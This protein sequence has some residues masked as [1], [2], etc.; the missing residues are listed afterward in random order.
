MDVPGTWLRWHLGSRNKP[1]N[2]QTGRK[3]KE[4]ILQFLLLRG[5][6][7]PPGAKENPEHLHLEKLLFRPISSSPCSSAS[8]GIIL[9]GVSG[10]WRDRKSDTSMAL[11]VSVCKSEGLTIWLLCPREGEGEEEEE[12]KVWGC[13]WG[14]GC[15]E[16]FCS[17]EE[18]SFLTVTLS[19]AESRQ[20]HW[21]WQASSCFIIMTGTL[22]P[23]CWTGFPEGETKLKHT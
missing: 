20:A 13:S 16:A 8:I 9:D 18:F 22:R 21:H 5:R 11:N 3:K 7:Y 4:S 15:S 14:A 1:Q 23:I 10:L 19:L 6:F 2:F 17:G 12:G